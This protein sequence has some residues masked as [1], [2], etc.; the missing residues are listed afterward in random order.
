MT[1]WSLEFGVWS[2]RESLPASAVMGSEDAMNARSRAAKLASSEVMRFL[3][4]NVRLVF[5]HSPSRNFTAL[6]PDRKR[7]LGGGLRRM[8]DVAPGRLR[9]LQAVGFLR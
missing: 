6:P 9:R 7:R 5:R 4:L 2:L 1:F 8:V 3:F